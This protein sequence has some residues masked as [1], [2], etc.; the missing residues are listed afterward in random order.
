MKTKEKIFVVCV[1]SLVALVGCNLSKSVNSQINI[2]RNDL[3]PETVETPNVIPNGLIDPGVG[4]DKVRLE[5]T[6]EILTNRLGKPTE[7]FHYDYTLSSGNSCDKIELRWTESFSHGDDLYAYIK[8]GRV[9]EIDTSLSNYSTAQ[10]VKFDMPLTEVL[11]KAGS[12]ARLMRLNNS[13]G[14]YMGGKDFL[15]LIDK[16]EG[17]AY[18]FYYHRKEKIR[19][20]SKIIIFR[21]DAEFVPQG[22]LAP[23][24]SL[25]EVND[26]NIKDR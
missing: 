7:R 1:I 21:K 9:F 18:E 13:A 20:L 15:Y 16:E 22:C 19:K 24:R 17:I 8:D 11:E 10:G 3:R 5:E 6:E 14:E 2:V 23:W 12:S 26:K 25:T 4:I